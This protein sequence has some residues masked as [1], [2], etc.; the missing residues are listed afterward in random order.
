MSVSVRPFRKTGRANNGGWE[1]D[2]RLRLA[3]GKLY[4]ERVKIAAATRADALRWGQD[5]EANILRH[6][7]ERRRRKRA[8][9]TNATVYLIRNDVTGLLKIG[10]TTDLTARVRT[11]SNA[12]GVALRV[13]GCINGVVR[14]E[15][16]LHDHFRHLRKQGEWFADAPE[17]RQVFVDDMTEEQ[18]VERRTRELFGWDR[19]VTG[20][21]AK[22]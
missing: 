11:L 21:E 10:F 22:L 13:L 7:S 5:R 14:Y 20:K 16:T 6:G 9:L 12:G 17:I 19:A 18:F 15:R 2:V 1:V 4:R 3:N 8:S